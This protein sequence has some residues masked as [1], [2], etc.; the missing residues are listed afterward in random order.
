VCVFVYVVC[1]SFIRIIH[2]Y[3]DIYMYLNLQKKVENLK[4]KSFKQ[5]LKFSK[6][7]VHCALRISI[8]ILFEPEKFVA[9]HLVSFI[10][11]KVSLHAVV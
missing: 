11:G 5:S 10:Q 2:M 1:L 4:N 3:L 9:L 7:R 6:S 8:W